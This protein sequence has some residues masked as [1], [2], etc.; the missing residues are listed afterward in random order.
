[1]FSLKQHFVTEHENVLSVQYVNPK[2]IKSSYFTKVTAVNWCVLFKSSPD[3]V[4][5]AHAKLEDCASE[6]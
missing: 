1:M 2:Y 5:A 4:S 6:I 3:E